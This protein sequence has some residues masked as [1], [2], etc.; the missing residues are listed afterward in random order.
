MY[1]IFF[2]NLN[3]KINF[4]RMFKSGDLLSLDQEV[5]INHASG[6]LVHLT[7]VVNGYPFMYIELIENGKPLGT[8]VNYIITAPGCA[9]YCSTIRSTQSQ[10]KTHLYSVLLTC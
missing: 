9:V 8:H 6:L 3:N 10:E 1:N 2:F 4:K 7:S 5:R